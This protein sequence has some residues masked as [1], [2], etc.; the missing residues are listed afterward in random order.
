[1]P[2]LQPLG[3]L[4]L[5]FLE[6]VGRLSIFAGT[7][8]SHCFRPPFYPKLILKQM[9]EVGYYSL[10]VVGLTAIFTG[11][12]LALQ[13]YTGFAR[14]SAESAIPN[15]VI[16][17]ITRE[18]GPVLAGLMVA[19]RVGAAM[20]AE[21]GTMRVTE[22][23]DALYTLATNPFKYLIAPRVIAGVLT[24]PLLVLVADTIGVF[25][26]YLVSVHKLG[27]NPATYIKNT[28]DFMEN[29]DVISGLVK[30]AAFGFIITLMG[31]YHGFHSRGGAQGVGAATTN[32]VVSASI[33]I[34]TFNYIITELF[35]SI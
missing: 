2:I 14:F 22:Q 7:A 16:V 35:F 21:I 12:V 31:C 6:I 15:V 25:G 32:A 10:P 5:R 26:G 3:N 9:I 30:A 34:L 20:A 13:S 1:M 27:F 24:L 19:G 18:L 28:I 29:L 17:S 8:I 33:L 23:I 4:T 11:M